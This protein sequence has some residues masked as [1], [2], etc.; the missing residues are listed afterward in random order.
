MV[1]GK[2]GLWRR[3]EIASHADII[4]LQSLSAMG[5]YRSVDV[6][7]RKKKKKY[8]GLDFFPQK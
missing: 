4:K 5:I 8:S 2:A 1:T 7:V 6:E 3:N